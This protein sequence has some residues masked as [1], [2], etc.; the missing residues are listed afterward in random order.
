MPKHLT[1]FADYALGAEPD[2][3]TLPVGYPILI[4]GVLHEVNAAQT[5]Y[6]PVIIDTAPHFT[7]AGGVA[8][9]LNA[10]AFGAGATAPGPDAIAIGS[11]A[12]ATGED[13]VVIGLDAVSADYESV[14][15][16][17]LA[18]ADQED[19]VVIGYSAH[20][21]DYESVAIGPY[22]EALNSDAIAI[23]YEAEATDGY[24]VAIGY[25]AI[26]D[27]DS[28]AIGESAEATGDAAVALGYG[29][30]AA[31]NGS[32][33]LGEGVSTDYADQVKLGDALKYV[34]SPGAM[35]W[36]LESFATS[37]TQSVDFTGLNL[38]M[39]CDA[40]AGNQDLS[41][42]S[43]SPAGRVVVVKKADGGANTVTINTAG[44]ETIDGA[45]S[46]VLSAAWEKVMLIFNGTN[47]LTI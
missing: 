31:F 36:N 12:T 4:D 13:S 8:A 16:G 39:A 25:Y 47:W 24:A 28:V 22:A 7:L 20:S 5:G 17:R 38:V 10:L 6:D 40:T 32:V 37:G 11:G 26:A 35:V 3:A 15:I 44:A 18:T 19:A 42:P 23:G 45:A 29:S 33:A 34:E 30:D 27:Y 21:A 2:P 41:L 1:R 14:A 9:G 46:L 43:G